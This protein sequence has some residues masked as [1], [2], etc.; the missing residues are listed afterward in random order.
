MASAF[1]SRATV[2]LDVTIS[3]GDWSHPC[4][5]FLDA[6]GWPAG[7]VPR[8][9]AGYLDL[10]KWE[11]EPLASSDRLVLTLRETGEPYRMILDA[12][13]GRF[14]ARQLKRPQIGACLRAATVR[15]S[16]RQSSQVSS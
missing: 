1:S 12:I 10:P 3:T 4:R 15:E 6:G 16:V 8:E 5:V 11:W 2:T 14:I 13:T 9:I 7:A